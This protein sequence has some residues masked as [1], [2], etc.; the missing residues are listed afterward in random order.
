MSATHSAPQHTTFE[1]IARLRE[2]MACVYMGNTQA[3]DRLIRCLLARGHMLIE[4]VPGV[5]KTV[6]ATALARSLD[7]AFSRI[8]MTPDLLP[9]DVLGVNML[10]MKSGAFEFKPG[11]VFANIVLADEINRTTPRTQTALLEAMGEATVSIDG[12]TRQL[13]SPFMVVATQNPHDFEG[14]YPLPENQLDRFLMRTRLGYPE[15]AVEADILEKRPSA[16]HMPNIH[17]VATRAQVSQ[18]QDATDNVR[19]DRSLIDYIV[20]IAEATRNDDELTLGLS[21]RGSLAL[22]HAARAS[23]M[24]HGRDYCI[25]EDITANL[26]I[27]VG[28]RILARS[29]STRDDVAHQ[30]LDRIIHRVPSPA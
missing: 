18:W 20:A 27:V 1:G 8:Q 9:A 11:P 14:T 5:G 6:L 16:M 19:L 2:S 17:P 26:Q 10:D 25:P 13:E 29:Y 4:D 28:H 22:S 7:C 15:A 21:T 3:I 30:V 23:A 12:I 24:L